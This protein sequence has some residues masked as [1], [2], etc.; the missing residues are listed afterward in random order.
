M[1]LVGLTEKTEGSDLC[2]FL[3][4]WLPKALSDMFTTAP[5]VAWAHRIGPVDPASLPGPGPLL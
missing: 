4:N 5:V 2:T 3:E 1:R